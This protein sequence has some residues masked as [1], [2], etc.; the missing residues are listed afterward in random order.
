MPACGQTV[1]L[2]SSSTSTRCNPFFGPL[3]FF[4][5]RLATAFFVGEGMLFGCFSSTNTHFEILC[6]GDLK[7]NPGAA[8]PALPG[9]PHGSE[10]GARLHFLHHALCGEQD[11]VVYLQ[12]SRHLRDCSSHGSTGLHGTDHSGATDWRFSPDSHR[13][14]S[15]LF[16]TL[17]GLTW[18]YFAEKFNVYFQPILDS[19]GLLLE[20]VWLLVPTMLLP[21][22]SWKRR[23]DQHAGHGPLFQ[24][25]MSVEAGTALIFFFGRA[26]SF[27]SLESRGIFQRFFEPCAEAVDVSRFVESFLISMGL[28]LLE[29]LF[30]SVLWVKDD[31]PLSASFS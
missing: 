10:T 24:V 25:F 23:R 18:D 15:V 31:L 6:Q 21:P 22:I 28:M 8:H 30:L 4:Q 27:V 12:G 1:T 5:W 26:R 16:K 29:D 11:L 3:W 20:D 7:K 19:W 14:T 9:P 2:W 13:K 17:F